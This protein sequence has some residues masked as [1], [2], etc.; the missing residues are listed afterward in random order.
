M[1][2][3]S[4]ITA[5]AGCRDLG[6]DSVSYS[7]KKNPSWKAKSQ[8]INRNLQN[9]KVHYR[10]HKSLS[11]V[12]IFSSNSRACKH[13]TFLGGELVAPRQTPKLKYHP[14]SLVHYY[15]FNIF[16]DIAASVV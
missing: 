1:K 16:A 4:P 8:E 7:V 2:E 14:L 9:P 13:R 12:P 3:K 15:L 10:I 5:S 6:G 11:P